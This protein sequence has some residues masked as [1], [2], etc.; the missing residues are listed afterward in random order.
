MV[1]APT[2][3]DRLTEV[4]R[5]AEG[6]VPGNG[7]GRRWLPGLGVPARRDDGMGASVCNG[8]VAPARVAGSVC[9]DLGDLHIGGDLVEK[10]RQHGRIPDVTS[11]NLDGADEKPASDLFAEHSA[12]LKARAGLV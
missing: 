12:R 2:S 8:V 9:R 3:P 10:L 4:L 11:G 5:G 1:S 6:L 7:G